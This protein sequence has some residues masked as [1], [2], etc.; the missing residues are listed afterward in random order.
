[1]DAIEQANIEKKRGIQIQSVRRRADNRAGPKE[2]TPKNNSVQRTDRSLCRTP[3]CHAAALIPV[4][5]RV[6]RRRRA[7]ESTC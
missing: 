2:P 6:V 1:M 5:E 3:P 4:K 7:L